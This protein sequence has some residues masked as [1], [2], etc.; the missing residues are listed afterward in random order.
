[1][2]MEYKAHCLRARVCADRVAGVMRV[3]VKVS[4]VAVQN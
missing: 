3:A 2:G 4:I 1:M